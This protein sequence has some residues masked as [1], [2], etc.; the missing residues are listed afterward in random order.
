MLQARS[1]LH[2]T[3]GDVD[4]MDAAGMPTCELLNLVCRRSN[5]VWTSNRQRAFTGPVTPNILLQH[6]PRWLV[7]ID[8]P[9][10]T[11]DT[12][13]FARAASVDDELL[14]CDIRGHSAF[15]VHSHYVR[16]STRDP[17]VPPAMASAVL[18]HHA[19][20]AL[21]CP[22]GLIKPPEVGLASLLIRQGGLLLRTVETECWP[23]FLD[24]GIANPSHEAAP[25]T[26]SV[27]FDRMTGHWHTD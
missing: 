2:R 3:V 11:R 13:A 19:A 16:I 7:A 8:G 9:V 12:N 4:I 20:E 17:E 26:R 15:K 23:G 1:L 14:D 18:Q 21:H 24:I 10:E 6:N 5:L 25:A 22:V 27:I